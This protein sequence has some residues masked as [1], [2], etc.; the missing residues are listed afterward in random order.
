MW[1][2][3]QAKE[4]AALRRH[5][6][7]VPNAA[8]RPTFEERAGTLGKYFA[9]PWFDG[10]NY[11]GTIVATPNH[12]TMIGPAGM[13]AQLSDDGIVEIVRSEVEH[14]IY[15]SEGVD[16]ACLT[17]RD[18]SARAGEPDL[19]EFSHNVGDLKNIQA[20]VGRRF[21]FARI[22]LREGVSISVA[23]KSGLAEQI[24]ETLWQVLYPDLQGAK[25]HDFAERHL[26]VAPQCVGVWGDRGIAVAYRAEPGARRLEGQEDRAL[27]RTSATLSTWRAGSIS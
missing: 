27:S 19:P 25:P 24:G 18:L 10:Q 15:R 8:A 17:L 4:V 20:P 5:D 12:G 11:F 1:A 16:G 9:D 2:R 14:S 3:L 13:D 21:R 7:Q 6:D 22:P 23:G 26:V